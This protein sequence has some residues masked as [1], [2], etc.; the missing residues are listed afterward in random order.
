MRIL[1]ADD[2]AVLRRGL[3]TILSEAFDP[4]VFGECGTT[5]E[6]L[7]LLE[8]EPW[9]LLI[10]DIF[11]PEGGG[12]E[13][14]RA[15]TQRELRL[16]VLVLSSAPEE[17]LAMRMLLAGAAGYLSKQTAAEELTRAVTRVLSGAKY[18]SNKLADRLARE[19][20]RPSLSAHENLSEREFQVLQLILEGKSLKEIAAEL[21]LSPKTIST[22]HTRLLDKLGLHNDVQLVYYALEHRLAERTKSSSSSPPDIR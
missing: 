13:V 20:V 21:S 7:A 5:T 14:L 4:V 8:R 19:F 17:Q 15:V 10:L 16:P 11:M 9:D 12:V 22:F 2:H 3:K 6:T 1:L 18:V